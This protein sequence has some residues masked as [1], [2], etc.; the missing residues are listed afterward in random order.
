M[1]RLLVLSFLAFALATVAATAAA[2]DELV[3]TEAPSLEGLNWIRGA[4]RIADAPLVV[5]W[6]TD[7]CPY[8][9]RS[10][11]ALKTLHERYADRGLVVVGVYHPKPVREVANERVIK[12]AG[13]L[14]FAFP[15]AVD[16]DWS[17]L[18]RWW[19]DHG[20]RQ[21]TSV[22]FLVD[23]DGTIRY[24]HAGGD[25]LLEDAN[26]EPATVSAQASDAGI[27]HVIREILTEDPGDGE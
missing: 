5:R 9:R 13:E 3:G 21:F 14:G 10:A 19:L 11:S 18:R 24:V 12:S 16:E 17:V 8:C 2:E 22:T 7:T 15:L 6:W 26:G 23:R 27:E 20:R 25:L 1:K 4:D